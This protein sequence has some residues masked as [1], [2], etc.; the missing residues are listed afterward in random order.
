MVR[1]HSANGMLVLEGSLKRNKNQDLGYIK[2]PSHLT[3]PE[4][5]KEKDET[6]EEE[7]TKH[8]HFDLEESKQKEDSTPA[9]T[10]PTVVK[11]KAEDVKKGPKKKKSKKE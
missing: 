11:R 3:I 2:L 10:Q 9:A 7:E 1:I 4:L 8:V 6:Q 5:P